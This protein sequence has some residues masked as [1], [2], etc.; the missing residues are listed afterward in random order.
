VEARQPGLTRMGKPRGLL[1]S[2]GA[3]L[4]DEELRL[5]AEPRTWRQIVLTPGRRFGDH[6]WW[7]SAVMDADEN[8]RGF[9]R[10][11]KRTR[12]WRLSAGGREHLGLKE[13]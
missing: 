3:R 4:S 11:D 2:A 6:A 13:D 7:R 9:L 5:F 8:G 10:W 12:T 1:A